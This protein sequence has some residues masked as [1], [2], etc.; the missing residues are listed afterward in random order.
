[1]DRHCISN[2][3]VGPVMFCTSMLFSY[4]GYIGLLSILVYLPDLVFLEMG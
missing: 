1:M 4:F 2:F 3:A